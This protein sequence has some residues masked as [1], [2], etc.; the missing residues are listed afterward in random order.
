M[1][2]ERLGYAY[3]A[4]THLGSPPQK[5]QGSHLSA[6]AD[7]WRPDQCRAAWWGRG[8]GGC[9]HFTED[10]TAPRGQKALREVMEEPRLK[11][12][13]SPLPDPNR[14]GPSVREEP[15]HLLI[16]LCHHPGLTPVWEAGLRNHK[17]THCSGGFNPQKLQ[18]HPIL[19][20]LQ[21]IHL[22]R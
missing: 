6:L 13:A 19:N 3:P 15:S 10:K 5:A 11:A 2:Q 12:R 21:V 1:A 14:C 20:C 4:L 8:G 22:N 7:R 17:P 9:L 18:L 16:P